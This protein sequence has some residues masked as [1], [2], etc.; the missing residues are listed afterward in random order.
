MGQSACE[1]TFFCQWRVLESPMCSTGAGLEEAVSALA[2]VSLSALP[3]A[4]LGELQLR[5]GGSVPDGST[6]AVCPTPAWLRAVTGA[7]GYAAGRQIR[8]S[9]R[10]PELP[11]VP[12]AVVA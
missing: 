6:G 8:A 7:S 3:V 12:H 11:R 1:L 4:A 5:S 10:V 9:V 2:A